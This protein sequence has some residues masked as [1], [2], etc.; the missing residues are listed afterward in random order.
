MS[1]SSKQDPEVVASVWLRKLHEKK[2]SVVYYDRALTPN[3]WAKVQRLVRDFEFP[4]MVENHLFHSVFWVYEHTHLP[5][6]AVKSEIILIVDAGELKYLAKDARDVWVK[7]APEF[8][9]LTHSL[10]N[11]EV[12]AWYGFRPLQPAEY[13]LKR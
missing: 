13:Y 12:L 2:N 5:L 6:T 4:C 10:R 1:S 3:E 9:A 8:T 7:A 11:A